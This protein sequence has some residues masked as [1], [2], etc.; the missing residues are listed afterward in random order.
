[1]MTEPL[2]E[3]D[4]ERIER[5]VNLTRMFAE[6]GVDFD[7]LYRRDCMMISQLFSNFVVMHSV[8]RT[9]RLLDAI[10]TAL[11]QTNSEQ[12]H[13]AFMMTLDLKDDLSSG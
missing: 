12:M 5:L 4:V 9:Q 10:Q 7:E 3:Y 6:E 2:T 13:D 1:M 8:E 11:V